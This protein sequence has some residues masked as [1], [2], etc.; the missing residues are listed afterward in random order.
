MGFDDGALVVSDETK[1]AGWAQG[2]TQV[3]DGIRCDRGEGPELL[4]LLW[5]HTLTHLHLYYGAGWDSPARCAST[6]APPRRGAIASSSETLVR[7]FVPSRRVLRVLIQ[8]V[9]IAR[10][11][12]Q[13]GKAEVRLHQIRADHR[14]CN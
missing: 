4:F 5:I 9:L 8:F 14:V 11:H 7:I 3:F 12:G 2:I 1:R 10:K 13:P 6:G